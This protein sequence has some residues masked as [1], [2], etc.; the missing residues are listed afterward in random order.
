LTRY[1]YGCVMLCRGRRWFGAEEE[2]RFEFT[3]ARS[4]A[5]VNH[6]KPPA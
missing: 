1:W 2:R 5:E 4:A 3:E 6:E